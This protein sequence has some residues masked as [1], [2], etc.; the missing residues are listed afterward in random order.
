MSKADIGRE[1]LSHFLVVGELQ[2]EL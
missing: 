2:T 1:R